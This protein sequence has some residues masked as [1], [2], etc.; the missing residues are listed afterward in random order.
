MR[1]A[2]QIFVTQMR[3]DSDRDGLFAGVE[4]HESADLAR[5]AGDHDSF[6]TK[7]DTFEYFVRRRF[8]IE[9]THSRS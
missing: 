4:T 5:V 6:A 2:D 9:A 8:L 1:R 3:A 7:I